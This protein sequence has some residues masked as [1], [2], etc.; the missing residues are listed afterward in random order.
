MAQDT[1]VA[2]QLYTI[3]D[4]MKKPEDMAVSLKKIREIGYK[5][6]Q[7]SGHGEVETEE[8]KKMLDNEGLS[9]CATHVRFD[10]LRDN[11]DAVMADHDILECK[12]VAIGSLPGEYKN[13]EGYKKFAREAS[14]GGKKMKEKGH[15]FGYHNHSF[16]LVKYGDRTA[17]AILY[18]DS[19]PEYFTAEIDTYWIQHGGGDPAAWIRK[20]S[21]RSPLVHFKDMAVT[22]DRKQVFAEVG[23]GNLNWPEILSACKEA[24]VEWYI[25]EQDRCQRD[26]FESL[27]I[28]LENMKEMGLS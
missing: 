5:A 16:E 23:E 11:L 28:S 12:Y 26:P 9:V 21:G 27:K 15:V 25:V 8:L 14:E 13:E 18:E 2:A 3:R 10:D 24:G 7:L 6:V 17:L 19:D 22:E 20:V 4:F 1:V